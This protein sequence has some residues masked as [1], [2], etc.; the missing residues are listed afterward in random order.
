MILIIF[1]IF[2]RKVPDMSEAFKGRRRVAPPPP[3]DFRHVDVASMH[4]PVRRYPPLE[5]PLERN[6]RDRN[7]SPS[8]PP[9]KMRRAPPRSPP[10]MHDDID[11][12]AYPTGHRPNRPPN[13]RP[14]EWADPWMR[15]G[16]MGMHQTAGRGGHRHTEDNGPLSQRQSSSRNGRNESL[17]S[18]TAVG[19]DGKV[20]RIPR[21]PGRRRSYSSGSSHSSSSGERNKASGAL[22]SRSRS[23]NQHGRRGRRDKGERRRR[24]SGSSRT[25]G[26][27]PSPHRR[28]NARSSSPE[29]IARKQG[30]AEIKRERNRSKTP[31]ADN[32]VTVVRI[33]SEH[34]PRGTGPDGLIGS[35]SQ[36]PLQKRLGAMAAGISLGPAPSGFMRNIKKENEDKRPGGARSGGNANL[37]PLGPRPT[38]S[39]QKPPG[40]RRRRTTTRSTSA[41][42]SSSREG[43]RS[44]SN[45]RF[46]RRSSGRRSRSPR[47]REIKKEPGDKHGG[48]TGSSIN[49]PAVPPIIHATKS[50]RDSKNSPTKTHQPPLP[51]SPPKEKQG[52]FKL[53][54]TKS[55]SGTTKP[56]NRTVLE[57]LGNPMVD[58]L[59]VPGA[60]SQSDSINSKGSNNPEKND[61]SH[62]SSSKNIKRKAAD[63]LDGTSSR[64]EKLSKKSNDSISKSQS[65]TSDKRAESKKEKKSAADRR[66]ELMKQLK[67]VENAIAKKRVKISN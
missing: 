60:H 3:D 43:R 59:T 14:D 33:K 18:P 42:S 17:Q 34:G 27:S 57:K 32:E 31:N 25:S 61:A 1:N 36:A 15:G 66:E 9:P 45:R 41:G 8:P 64:S 44:P 49:K 52:P 20:Q 11:S 63:P 23:K 19:E 54:F 4:G 50:V 6:M 58:G 40:S 55:S 26:S 24:S 30:G 7:Y 28:R 2:L 65:K 56:A 22:R 46:R 10:D 39:P 35:K 38:P 16:P 48:N 21:A 37:V 67:A 13:M 62:S 51:K 5:P 53:S 29:Y 47:G 12:G